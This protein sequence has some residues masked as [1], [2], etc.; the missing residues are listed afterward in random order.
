MKIIKRSG[1]EAV[2]DSNKIIAAVQK[3]NASVID[4]EKLSDEQIK[5]IADNVETACE[6][7]KRSPSVEEIQDMVENQLMNKRAFT[8]ARNYITYRYKRALV[9]KSNST[10]Q[11]ILSLL[12]CNN[13][14]VKQENSNKNPTVNSVQRDYM[15]GEVS[16]DITKSVLLA[17]D[18]GEAGGRGLK[19][20]HDAD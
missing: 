18:V 20:K 13:E 7:M 12:E 2:Y 6:N 15:A 10:D 8:V 3:A 17:E 9:R 1:S 19:Q 16:K 14:E 11:Q 5:E 4:Y